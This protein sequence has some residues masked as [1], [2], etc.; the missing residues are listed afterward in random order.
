[1][2]M[3]FM[4]EMIRWPQLHIPKMSVGWHNEDHAEER[5]QATWSVLD[6]D[7]NTWYWLHP[8]LF[9]PCKIVKMHICE[10]HDHKEAQD[11]V[12]SPALNPQ[13]QCN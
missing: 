10:H 1:M 8:L 3:I 5:H 2:D 6:L 12:N 9:A 7:K 11:T 13:D 4:V